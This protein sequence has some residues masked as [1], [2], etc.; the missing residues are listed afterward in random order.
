M[1]VMAGKSVSA[2][3]RNHIDVFG[4]T[5]VASVAAG[6]AS[7]KLPEVLS[8]LATLQRERTPAARER[9]GRCSPIP[10]SWPRSRCWWSSA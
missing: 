10:S 6:E 9:C 8:R 7:G 1:D 4:A 5:Y 3:L 2:A